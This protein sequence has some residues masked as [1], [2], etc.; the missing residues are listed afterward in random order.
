MSLPEDM[1]AEAKTL[2]ISLSRACERGL[3]VEISEKKAALWL[4]RN[5]AGIGEWNSFVEE[6][7]VPYARF[8]QF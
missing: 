2:G 4:E 8:R 6:N 7:G 5:Q 3:A 1:V